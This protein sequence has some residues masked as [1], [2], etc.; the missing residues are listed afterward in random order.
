MPDKWKKSNLCP[1]HYSKEK[2][3]KISNYRQ[4]SFLPKC[5]KLFERLILDSLFNY[6]QEN[7]LLSAHQSGIP[8]NDSG[9]SQLIAAV[10]EIYTA[11]NDNPTLETCEVFW[12]MSKAFDKAWHTGLF[13]I[14]E[15]M[16]VSGDL[17]KIIKDFLNNKFQ[18]FATWPDI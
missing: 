15:S 18:C 14:L 16:G 6:L 5:V 1:I 7:K 10:P 3:Q 8:C 17:L 9:V 4:V 12:D 11:F 13:Y 2:C